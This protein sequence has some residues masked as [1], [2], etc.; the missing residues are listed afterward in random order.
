MLIG[1]NY[2]FSISKYT[3]EDAP[4]KEIIDIA[5]SGSKSFDVDDSN[6]K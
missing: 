6:K 3:K 5:I 4:D 2:P 1:R